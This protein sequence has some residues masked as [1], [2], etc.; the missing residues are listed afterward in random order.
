MHLV[1]R[2]Q[3]ICVSPRFYQCGSYF[4]DHG[5][6]RPG[7]DV[8][9]SSFIHLRR[10]SWCWNISSL[11]STNCIQ[12][13]ERRRSFK[14]V[15]ICSKQFLRWNK[16]GQT[17][18]KNTSIGKVGTNCDKSTASV[19]ILGAQSEEYDCK[20]FIL[21]IFRNKRRGPLW[22]PPPIIDNLLTS[23][24]KAQISKKNEIFSAFPPQYRG[25]HS[26]H[27][28]HWTTSGRRST[29]TG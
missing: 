19:P 14:S 3:D 10:Y 28:H 7:A 16:S 22:A 6:K 27:V 20:T 2:W 12:N 15:C 9:C 11:S 23:N 24:D 8:Y 18:P 4:C 25:L 17:L 21:F 13:L 1:P 5:L 29:R 26:D